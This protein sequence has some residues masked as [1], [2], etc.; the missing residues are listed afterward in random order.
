LLK[1]TRIK[2]KDF[3]NIKNC[4]L[5][6]DNRIIL[7]SGNSGSGKSAI[8]EAIR[9]IFSSKKR[10][11][12]YNE[13]IR[14]GQKQALIHVE[15][16]IHN[17]PVII[18]VEM[19]AEY[20]GGAF[21]C[22]IQYDGS[23][24]KNT[25][26]NDL[27]KSFDLEYYSDIIL[28]MQNDIDYT[29]L[30]P[31]ARS[32][33]MA[34]LLNFDFVSQKERIKEDI[35]LL[36]TNIQQM[37]NQ[38]SIK[39]ALLD[40]ASQNIKNE[41]P[42]SELED[43]IFLDEKKN[44]E[45]E[46]ETLEQ[47][48]EKLSKDNEKLLELTTLHHNA[49]KELTELISKISEIEEQE[50]ESEDREKQIS[51]LKEEIKNEERLIQERDA[52]REELIPQ[53]NE[54][55]KKQ[56]VS[57]NYKNKVSLYT[58]HLIAISTL[59]KEGKC[60]HCGQST[61]E[62]SN[63][64]IKEIIKTA[65]ALKEHEEYY[66]NEELYNTLLSGPS[67]AD[68][69][70]F[71]LFQSS[72]AEDRYLMSIALESK[73]NKKLTEL[74]TENK[75]SERNV[76]KYNIE[77]SNF[78]IFSF[79]IEKKEPYI[80]SKRKKIQE[81]KELQEKID[82]IKIIKKDFSI[83]QEKKN[84]L[85]TVLQKIDAIQRKKE[86]AKRI[87]DENLKI[88]IQS[89]SLTK[90]IEEFEFQKA[91]F[92]KDLTVKTDTFKL[93]DKDLPNYMIVKTCASLE[94]EMNEFIHQIFP[95]YDVQLSQ[96]KAGTEFLYTQDR[97]L[98]KNVTNAW[99]NAK[100]SSGFERAMLTL[101][102]KQSLCKLYGLDICILDECDKAADDDSSKKLFDQIISDQTFNQLWII[103]HKKQTCQLIIDDNDDVKT[104]I[105]SK[106]TFSEVSNV[107]DD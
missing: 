32:Q 21:A 41:I 67:I 75:N 3:L 68:I 104:F 36:N 51:K 103:S 38:I 12:K 17:K 30:S 89:E 6:T 26:A 71:F 56:T 76:A 28:T 81:L 66:K 77:I 39:K 47:E 60:T 22:T 100:M 99:I 107:Y 27:I 18:D 2:L 63:T 19:N 95:N 15:G 74:E 23:E 97:T 14:Q 34:R 7:I 58:D 42:K 33:Y 85:N 82:G 105:A 54:E 10:S 1:I 31:A 91:E 37:A 70:D 80:L 20:R 86:E 72:S 9:V 11:D 50:K 24:K 90:E 106:G 55:H 69:K 43:D 16:E 78:N 84:C 59:L 29:E 53:I 49:E 8:L 45:N 93:I 87:I 4:D 57:V 52:Q 79:D 48:K 44:L 46:I 13:Y 73:L 94:Y 102:F 98:G 61:V 25:E 65:I 83:L 101:A 5:F 96:K 92:Q 35:E 64:E 88:K 62:H 40:N